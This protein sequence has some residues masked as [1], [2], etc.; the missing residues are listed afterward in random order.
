MP[1]TPTVPV[2]I[3]E[4]NFYVHDGTSTRFT[5]GD[6]TELDPDVAERWQNLGIAEILHEE[7]GEIEKQPK[8]KLT[9]KERAALVKTQGVRDEEGEEREEHEADVEDENDEKVKEAKQSTPEKKAQ[10]IRA[11]FGTFPG[12]SP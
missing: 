8:K 5:A 9:A 6:V 4:D 7:D 11:D 10:Q 1:N 3:H 2:Y 12:E